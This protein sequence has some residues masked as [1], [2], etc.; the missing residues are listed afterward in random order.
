MGGRTKI[1]PT[2]EGWLTVVSNRR[3]PHS[4]RRLTNRYRRRRS[5]RAASTGFPQSHHQRHSRYYPQKTWRSSAPLQQRRPYTY[6]QRPRSIS[7]LFP[8]RSRATQ[9]P[10]AYR[11]H[12]PPHPLLLPS[13]TPLP[14]K[15][16]LQPTTYPKLNMQHLVKFGFKTPQ[17]ATYASALASN[18]A[19]RHIPHPLPPQN[20]P[21]NYFLD[22][23]PWSTIALNQSD[24]PALS[25]PP[26]PLPPDPTSSAWKGRCYNCLQFGHDQNTCPCPDRV[27]AICWKKGHE[28]RACNQSVLSKRQRFDPLQPRGN[29][30]ESLLPSNRPQLATVFLPETRQM[31]TER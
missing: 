16:S 1:I 7:Q 17:S 20:Q 23:N 21:W 27:C 11:C 31:Q 4:Y 14:P 5:Y 26:L 22:Q 9:N 30:G 12:L 25:H 19:A 3:S 13:T 24:D 18:S 6:L 10:P 2:G 28:A 15:H 8:L 29:L